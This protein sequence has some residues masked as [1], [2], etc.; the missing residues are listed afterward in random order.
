MIATDGKPDPNANVDVLRDQYYNQ[1]IKSDHPE[2]S[3]DI[4]RNNSFSGITFASLGSVYV[5]NNKNYYA[6]IGLGL[7][8]QVPWRFRL[9]SPY[10]DYDTNLDSY[11]NDMIGSLNIYANP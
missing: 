5:V 6:Y 4:T 2:A 1:E 8:Q 10:D 11:F 3:I 9:N 7:R